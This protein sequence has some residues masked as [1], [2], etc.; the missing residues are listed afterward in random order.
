[1]T[2]VEILPEMSASRAATV[3]LWGIGTAVPSSLG[4]IRILLRWQEDL[5]CRS[6]K[7]TIL[8]HARVFP[9]AAFAERRGSVLVKEGEDFRANLRTFYPVRSSDSDLGPTTAQRG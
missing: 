8:S 3:G 9:R 4:Q 2:S 7:R 1:M 6:D 5:A